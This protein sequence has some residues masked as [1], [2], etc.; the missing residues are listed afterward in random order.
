M[1]RPSFSAPRPSGFTLIELLVVIAIIAVLMGLLLPAVQKVREAAQRIK[2]ASNMRQLALAVHLYG[3]DND[4]RLPPSNFYRVVNPQTGRAAEGSAFY[5]TLPYYEQ[6][7]LFRQYTQDRPDAGYL[8]GQYVPLALHVCPS[9]PTSNRGVATLDGKTATSNYALNLALFGAGGTFNVKGAAPP[10]TIGTIPDGTS[11]TIMMVETSGCFPGF[12]AVDPQTGTPEN[13]MSWPYPAYPNTMGP[14]WPNPD[15]LPGQ[16]HHTGSFPL[17]QIGVNPQKADPNL[18]QSYHTGVMNVA[19]MDGS[20]RTVSAG[21]SLAT[22]SNALDPD[23]GQ[24]LGS[25]W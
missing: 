10:Y 25:D 6:E 19:L 24:V 13:F 3:G 4:G 15:E 23:D 11:N 21:L 7:T 1:T 14:Y 9:D 17:P 5:V 12:P 20:V 8:G 22:W 18:C 2:C 16:V